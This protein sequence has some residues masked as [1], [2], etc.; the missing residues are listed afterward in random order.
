MTQTPM[1]LIRKLDETA[2][3]LLQLAAQVRHAVPD[4]ADLELRRE[5]L[6]SADGME[7]RAQEMAAVIQQWRREI[8]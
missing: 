3:A 2:A 6:E 8:N 5:M 1:D 7:R 4:V